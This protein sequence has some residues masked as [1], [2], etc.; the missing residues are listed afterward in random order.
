MLKLMK[1][2]FMTIA[3]ELAKEHREISVAEF[4]ERNKHLL[5]FENLQKSLLTCV[6]EAVDNAL[7][8]C[9]DARILPQIYVELKEIGENRF[10]I[11]VEDNGPGIVKK[12]I[13]KIFAKLLYGG[14][15]NLCQS[16]GQQ[17]I[18][19]SASVLY[20]QLTT[21]KPTKIYSRIGDGK[22]HVYVLH[23]NI[24]KN[25]PEII[26]E[27]TLTGVN[28]HGTRVEMEIKGK[29][30]KSR[31]S[32]NEY[33]QQTAIMN[34]FAQIIYIAPDGK[35]TEF[36]RVV[37]KL[38]P[39]SKNIKPHP[40]GVELGI[41]IRMLRATTARN[42]AGFL[43]SDFSSIGRTTAIKV[44]EKAEVDHKI[45]PKSITRSEADKI[46]DALQEER[47]QKPPTNCLSPIG[48]DAIREGLT[49]EIHPEFV[50]T[51]SRK[52]TVYS[53]HPFIV[54]VG[55]AYGGDLEKEGNISLLRFANKVP[56][57][58]RQSACALTKS[59]TQTS[60]RRYGLKQSSGALPQGPVAI[61]IHFASVWIPYTSESKEAIAAYPVIMK[62]VR[63]ALQEVS[64]KLALYLS[65]KRRSKYQEERIAMFKR[66]AS[67]IAVA[68]SG[69]TG[70]EKE[71]IEENMMKL[72]EEKIKKLELETEEN[73][74]LITEDVEET[75]EKTEDKFK[76][77][78]DIE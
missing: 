50:A 12:N 3:K 16:R 37:D 78:G 28:G 39:K 77:N 33:L 25:E 59:V 61:L 31:L 51:L 18:G 1:S 35:E 67:E 73:S 72:V 13:P 64:R 60:W 69:L 42:I 20:A 26:S 63:L 41:L 53:G 15:F 2:D 56:L 40:H 17:G 36:P 68:L 22:S 27:E 7:D 52:P 9:E 45:S 66:Y 47:I 4:F 34:P 70:K 49:K 23:I 11:I 10:K 71:K 5:G 46:L 48:A 8:A 75:E 65:K 57:L 38:P 55:I 62:E 24:S 21:G 76:E 54:E 6:R 19:I 74:E 58:Y 30:I 29:Y 44:C 43:T 14:K 32:V